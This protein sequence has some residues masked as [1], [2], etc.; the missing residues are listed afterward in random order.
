MARTNRS[1]MLDTNGDSNHGEHQANGSTDDLGGLDDMMLNDFLEDP[2]LD[3]FG[4]EDLQLDFVNDFPDPQLDIDPGTASVVPPVPETFNN[5]AQ[6]SIVVETLKSPMNDDKASPSKKKSKNSK[7]QK[8]KSKVDGNKSQL[9]QTRKPKSRRGLPTQKKRK[10]DTDIK[11]PSSA[12]VMT[13]MQVQNQ[14]K[15]NASYA[16]FKMTNQSPN[17]LGQIGNEILP[18][19]A[20][21][22]SNK[23]I[24]T[25]SS[26][27]RRQRPSSSRQHESF[28]APL[29][30]VEDQE[31]YFHP[32][33]NVECST[34]E[35]Y[36]T[37]YPNLYKIFT[38]SSSA[39]PNISLNTSG[40]RDSL[41]NVVFNYV[42]TRIEISPEYLPQASSDYLKSLKNR[43]VHIGIDEESVDRSKALIA[44]MHKDHIISE[45]RGL[46]DQT[47]Q[48]AK[49]LTKQM[50]HMVG[51]CKEKFDN[52]SLAQSST[53]LS[54]GDNS[55]TGVQQQQRKLPN[56]ASAVADMSIN[57]GVTNEVVDKIINAPEPVPLE[58]S[59]KVTLSGMKKSDSPLT[60]RILPVPGISHSLRMVGMPCFSTPSTSANK[61]KSLKNKPTARRRKS[62]SNQSTVITP[63]TPR[64]MTDLNPIKKSITVDK[65][66]KEMEQV[67][68]RKLIKNILNQRA[69]LYRQKIQNVNSKKNSGISAHKQKIQD[70]IERYA[71]TPMESNQFWDMMRLFGHW[72]DPEQDQIKNALSTIW[73]PELPQREIHW[74]EMSKPIV[75]ILNSKSDNKSDLS[76]SGPLFD[77]LQS[78]LVEEDEGESSS[79]TV[80]EDTGHDSD[81]DSLSLQDTMDSDLVDLSQLS[82]D[83]RTYIH[84]RSAHLIDQSLLPSLVPSVFE[85][86]HTNQSLPI[87][88]KVGKKPI[89][90]TI[91]EKQKALSKEHQTNNRRVSKLLNLANSDHDKEREREEE[92]LIS[93]HKTIVKLRNDKATSVNKEKRKISPPIADDEWN[94]TG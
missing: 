8:V 44:T 61:V 32:F 10:I 86:E 67:E 7:R 64:P 93:R 4:G 36:N 40:R 83:Q 71:H 76:S 30:Q 90:V 56:F 27:S 57:V 13:S 12:S 19:T 24:K 15:P 55:V 38:S 28:P 69:A 14:S 75:T 41:M 80:E 31:N 89:S 17:S 25:G 54:V 34:T 51:W 70:I 74:G 94:P 29:P 48:E 78:L 79:E 66:Y 77:R 26:S 85:D 1:Q 52:E 68:K 22:G 23:K 73:Q 59:I 49:F 84:L 87:R 62:T 5:R 46:L 65:P 35:S 50:H 3:L 11:P 91:R 37:I 88:S 18:N 47:K 21:S 20:N 63:S 53:P 82:V 45:L 2:L 43:D 58:I 39:S 9:P 6:N 72:D 42:G 33:S 16:P 60:A 81:E 92:I